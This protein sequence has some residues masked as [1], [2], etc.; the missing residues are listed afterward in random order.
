[1]PSIK[2]LS[3]LLC[4]AISCRDNSMERRSGLGPDPILLHCTQHWFTEPTSFWFQYFSPLRKR[5]KIGLVKIEQHGAALS[6]DGKNFLLSPNQGNKYKIK[7][8]QKTVFT[9]QCGKNFSLHAV[10]LTKC[11]TSVMINR[12]YSEHGENKIWIRKRN[13]SLLTLLLPRGLLLLQPP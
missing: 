2:G 10:F 7:D 5:T 6:K 3:F 12:I 1:M 13:Y 9:M 4:C 11:Q 8:V